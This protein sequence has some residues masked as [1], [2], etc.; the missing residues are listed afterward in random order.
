[1]KSLEDD[2]HQ[3]M[4]DIYEVAD[5]ECN[6]RA[7]AFL[8]MVVE[9]GGL[10]TAK[11]LLSTTDIQS[12][13][14]E[15]FDCGRIDLTVEALV[16]EGDYRDLFEREELIEAERRLQLFRLREKKET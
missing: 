5:S 16:T 10:Q 1:M 14:H 2:F 7:K 9:M 8:S 12:G 11:K 6:Y 13:L 4:I 3:A 15:L